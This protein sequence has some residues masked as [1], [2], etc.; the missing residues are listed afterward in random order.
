MSGQRLPP[1]TGRQRLGR[2]GLAMICVGHGIGYLIAP[3]RAGV[4]P[5]GLDLISASGRLVPWWGAAWLVLGL[6]VL[7]AA[8]RSRAGWGAV[9]VTSAL[10]MFWGLAYLAG[11]ILA[12]VLPDVPDNRSYIV[13]TLYIGLA[14]LVLG[15]VPQKVRAP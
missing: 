8:V 4:L 14:L 6:L 5:F 3:P 1:I 9:A 12:A 15:T 7:L 10:S 11:F 2:L 13:S